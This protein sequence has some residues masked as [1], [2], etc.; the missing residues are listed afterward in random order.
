MESSDT[1][2]PFDFMRDKAPLFVRHIDGKAMLVRT[3]CGW[4]GIL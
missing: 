4:V 2:L 3:L 1:S